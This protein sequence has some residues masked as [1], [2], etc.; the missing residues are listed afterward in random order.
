MQQCD[1]CK[2]MTIFKTCIDCQKTEASILKELDGRSND[3]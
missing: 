2:K 3:K 1:I